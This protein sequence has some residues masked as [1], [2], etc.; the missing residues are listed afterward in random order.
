M[1][2]KYYII[3]EF[4]EKPSK[5]IEYRTEYERICQK[6]KGKGSL[7][8]DKLFKADDSSLYITK[9]DGRNKHGRNILWKRP[10]VRFINL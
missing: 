4:V 7:W 10:H 3:C 1:Y 5:H 8:E 9:K 6:C 2:N